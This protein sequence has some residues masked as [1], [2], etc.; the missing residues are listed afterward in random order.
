MEEDAVIMEDV[1]VVGYAVGS[2]KTISG[3][4]EKVGRDQM[5]AGVV[6]NPL[7]SIKGKVAG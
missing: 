3:S 2:S 4:V 1:V 5:N 6:V 7:Q